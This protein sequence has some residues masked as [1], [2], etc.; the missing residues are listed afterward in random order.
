MTV[1]KI[2]NP[3]GA[4]FTL[5]WTG[6]WM[7]ISHTCLRS[8]P[9]TQLQLHATLFKKLLLEKKEQIKICCTNHNKLIITPLLL[10]LVNVQRKSTALL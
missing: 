7:A 9:P 1:F 2:S 6:E 3:A 5:K 4:G 8:Y 10:F